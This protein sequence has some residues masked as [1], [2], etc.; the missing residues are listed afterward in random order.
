M[1]MAAQEGHGNV[2]QALQENNANLNQATKPCGKTLVYMAAIKGHLDVVKMLLE[3]DANPD[4]A[5]TIDGAT[6]VYAVVDQGYLECLKVLL[7]HGANPN[8]ATTST[9]SISLHVAAFKGSLMHN[10]W[11]CMEQTLLQSTSRAMHL[12]STQS[13]TATIHSPSGWMLPSPGRR[14]ELL[15]RC[16]CTPALHSCFSKDG[17]TRMTASRFLQR[18]SW[19]RLQ[20]RA[21]R[22]QHCRGKPHCTLAKQQSSL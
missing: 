16:G 13:D 10:S 7:E 22:R 1:F 11:Q 21:Q 6:A 14:Y 17:S 12:P 5:N 4:L 15:Q 8:Q 18:K 19:Q 2:V 20:H 3:H 9:G